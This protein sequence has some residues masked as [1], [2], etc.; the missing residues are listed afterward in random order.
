MQQTSEWQTHKPYFPGG[1]L[2]CQPYWYLCAA[3]NGMVFRRFG[4]K[5]GIDFVHF[6]LELGTVFE[7][8]TGVNQRIYMY[9]FNSSEYKRKRNMRIRN[10]FQESFFFS[11]L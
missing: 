11:I 8:T 4:L 7:K 6:G 5:T 9:R 10:G 1:T 3:P 2:L